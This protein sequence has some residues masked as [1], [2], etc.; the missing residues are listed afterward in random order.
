MLAAALWT[1][2]AHQRGGPIPVALCAMSALLWAAV[3]FTVVPGHRGAHALA[4][5]AAMV[6]AAITLRLTHRAPI[7]HLALITAGAL[8]ALTS[9]VAVGGLDR[10]RTAALIGVVALLL[11]FAAPRLTVV[12][13]K[14]PLPPVPSPGEPI[15]A[16]EVPLCRRS[17][18]STPSR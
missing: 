1:G 17:T 2:R 7:A 12:L 9:A 16:V 18:R 6:S 4:A 3:G 15:D 13:A 8:A 5:V 14:I 11:T 10:S